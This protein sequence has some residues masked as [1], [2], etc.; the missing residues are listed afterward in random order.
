MREPYL[1]T[2]P[3]FSDHR[4][5]LSVIEWAECFPFIPKRFYY[6]YD[7]NPAA[8][9]GSHSHWK[10]EEVFLALSGSISVLLDN[11]SQRTEFLLDRPDIAL[12]IPPLVWHEA[13]GFSAGALCA[14]FASNPY[15]KEDYCL[16][17]QQFIGACRKSG[18]DSLS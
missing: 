10:E 5:S 7:T 13:F 8:R 17:Y 14:V 11:G 16:D 15:N 2:I 3:R 12:Y 6:I 9:R 18:S 4:G 1:I